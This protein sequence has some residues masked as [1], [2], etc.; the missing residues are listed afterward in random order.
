ME[1]IKEKREQILI[2]QESVIG[3]LIKDIGTFAM[4]AGLLYFN[5][6][7]LGGHWIVDVLFIMLVTSWL[8]GLKSSRVYKGNINGAIKFLNEI[9][10]ASN[11]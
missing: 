11:D 10:E 1:N 5:H 8:Q 2:L 7:Y 3:S 4:F 6:E 9:K